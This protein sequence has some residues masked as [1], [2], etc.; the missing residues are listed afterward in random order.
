[1][2]FLVLELYRG[3]KYLFVH[4]TWAVTWWVTYRGYI[5]TWVLVGMQS[6]PSKIYFFFVCCGK[7]SGKFFV[8]CRSITAV[9]NTSI[10]CRTETLLLGIDRSLCGV[11]ECVT[12][13]ASIKRG[14]E[15]SCVLYLKQSFFLFA[16]I[17]GRRTHAP[18][19]VSRAFYH[20]IIVS[21][22]KKTPLRKQPWYRLQC[23]R[24]LSS[25]WCPKW[26]TTTTKSYTGKSTAAVA[27]CSSTHFYHGSDFYT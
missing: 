15:E 10:P 17:T 5:H 8:A 26:A 1:M 16:S 12:S 22:V 2:E 9:S 20:D 24:C 3:F 11:V 18:W 23:C 27:T 19:K 25:R 21:D 4:I 14:K 7:F 13:M 6:T